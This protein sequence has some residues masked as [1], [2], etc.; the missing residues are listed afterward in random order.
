MMPYYNAAKT[1]PLALASLIA[2][3]YENWECILVDDGSTDC[4]LPI[5]EQAHDRRIKYFRLDKNMG[6]G[7]ARQ[8]ALDHATGSYLCM[9]DADDWLYPSKL[10]RQVEVMQQEPDLALVSS[11]I[12]IVNTQNEIVGVRCKGAP[13]SEMTTSGPL[14]RLAPPSVAF[15]PCMIRMGIA[16]QVRFDPSLR[17]SEDADFLLRILLDHSYY[18]LPDVLYVYAEYVWA[19]QDIWD[20][21]KYRMRMFRKYSQRFPLSSLVNVGKTAAKL[22]MYRIVFALGLE[23]WMIARRSEPPTAEEANHFE[24]ARQAVSAVANRLCYFRCPE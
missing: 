9:L 17:R 6:R 16:K 8:V 15:A 19:T 4:P 14:T 11:G 13:D 12:A 2:Q 21:H 22:A 5:I 20:G 3:T 10:Q 23:K 1:L 18:V 24:Q 7:M